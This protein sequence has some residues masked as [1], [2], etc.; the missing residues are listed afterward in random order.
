MLT[1]VGI[2]DPHCAVFHLPR[3]SSYMHISRPINHGSAAKSNFHVDSGISEE[4]LIALL[5][6]LKR[7]LMDDSVKIVDMTSQT[8]RVSPW[9]FLE[10]HF[11]FF[12]ESIKLYY[13][14]CLIIVP[15]MIFSLI[16]DLFIH[17]FSKVIHV[18]LK[19]KDYQTRFV[20]S[21]GPK[22]HVQTHVHA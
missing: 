20:I 7:Y 4:F 14:A 3:D 17:M 15:L 5:K 8:L 10:N 9:S 12:F 11:S 1:Q 18:R 2:G 16:G 19:C 6:V 22:L 21:S 13:F